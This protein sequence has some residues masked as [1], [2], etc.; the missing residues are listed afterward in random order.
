MLIDGFAGSTKPGGLNTD[1]R[2]SCYL[3]LHIANKAI[4]PLFSADISYKPLSPT[5]CRV[6][7]F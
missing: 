1:Y 2:E 6:G 5:S 4:S 3:G 7:A